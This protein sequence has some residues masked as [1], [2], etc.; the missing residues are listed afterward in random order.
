MQPRKHRQKCFKVFSEAAFASLASHLLTLAFVSCV[1]VL[2]GREVTEET[3]L[4]VEAGLE[5]VFGGVVLE[6]VCRWGGMEALSPGGLAVEGEDFLNMET[7]SNWNKKK[8]VWEGNRKGWLTLN[9]I[10][11][12]NA[13]AGVG[14]ET[15]GTA[16]SLRHRIRQRCRSWGTAEVPRLHQDTV[17]AE[18]PPRGCSVSLPPPSTPF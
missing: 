1:P 18:P 6:E 15:A 5:G 7:K 16:L 4:E 2:A 10:R 11:R 8:S 3:R 17:T 13:E 12:C 14:Q 9:R